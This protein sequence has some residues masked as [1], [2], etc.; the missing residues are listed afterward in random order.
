[1]LREEDLLDPGVSTD[2]TAQQP[3]LILA[4]APFSA[5]VYLQDSHS[6]ALGA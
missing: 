1:M 5:G 6:W 3:D 4:A 2:L